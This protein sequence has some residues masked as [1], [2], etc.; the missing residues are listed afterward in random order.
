MSLQS[1]VLTLAA[2]TLAADVAHAEFPDPILGQWEAAKFKLVVRFLPGEE[3]GS[4]VGKVAHDR[5]PHQANHRLCTVTR[6]DSPP[7]SFDPTYRGMYAGYDPSGNGALVIC[8]CTITLVNE[9][10]VQWLRVTIHDSE[11]YQR[12]LKR[13]GL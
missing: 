11:P 10:G 7:G 2:A 3:P 5:P 1:L 13:I 6:T 8:P 9:R 4:L 12:N